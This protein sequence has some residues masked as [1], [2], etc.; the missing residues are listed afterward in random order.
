MTITP[1]Q[2]NWRL[3]LFIPLLVTTS[4]CTTLEKPFEQPQTTKMLST[5]DRIAPPETLEHASSQSAKSAYLQG[6][7]ETAERHYRALLLQRPIDTKMVYNLTM[8]QLAQA[9]EGLRLY[10]SIEREP[11]Q[12]LRAKRMLEQLSTLADQ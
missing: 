10:L 8:V 12:Q 4:A 9:H 11:A 3:L 6:D 5:P 7:Y 1:V 2:N